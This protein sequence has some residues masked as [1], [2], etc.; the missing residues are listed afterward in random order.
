[1]TLSIKN[2]KADQLARELARRQSR[3]ITEVVLA[4]L[5]AKLEREKRRANEKNMVEDLRKIGQRYSALPDFDT[6]SEDEILGYDEHG[7]PR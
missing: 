4:A 1:M 7:I 5:E 6:R 2:P 3:T